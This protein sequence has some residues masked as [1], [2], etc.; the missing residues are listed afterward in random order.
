M[1]AA[2]HSATASFVILYCDL[3]FQ[4]IDVAMLL[5]FN[6]EC[7]SIV[8]FKFIVE[9]LPGAWSML[10][11]SLANYSHCHLSLFFFVVKVCFCFVLV[12]HSCFIY[13]SKV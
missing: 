7:F 2:N 13:F 3:I 1:Q 6:Y 11:C 8:D 12:P 9:S 10:S 5:Y 4:T